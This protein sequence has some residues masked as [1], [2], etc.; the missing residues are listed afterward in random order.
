MKKKDDIWF[1]YDLSIFSCKFWNFFKY[2]W[3]EAELI[4]R[5]VLKDT[6]CYKSR[7]FYWLDMSYCFCRYGATTY[8]YKNFQFYKKRACY[9]DSY[10]TFR[11]YVKLIQEKMDWDTHLLFKQKNEFNKYYKDFIHRKWAVLDTASTFDQIYSFIEIC[12]GKAIVKPLDDMQGH[13]IYRINSKNTGKIDDLILQLRNG[14]RFLLEEIVENA[15]SLKVINPTSL[16]TVRVNTLLDKQLNVHY[17]NFVLRVGG[18]NAEVDNFSS[19]GVIYSINK[20]KGV[21]DNYGTDKSGSFFAFHPSTNV[22]MLGL[23]IPYF[24]D[25]KRF[26]DRIARLNPKAKLVGWDIAITENGFELIE[27]NFAADETI[28]QFD[29]KGKYKYILEEW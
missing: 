9:R 13:G 16:N 6:S 3:K 26:V 8:N 27:G 24:A 20:D 11:R 19:G 7:F 14:S 1:G 23:E 4:R 22:P 29:G 10:L 5:L 2:A 25:L 15:Q 21:V 17:L 18:T 12:G 28:M